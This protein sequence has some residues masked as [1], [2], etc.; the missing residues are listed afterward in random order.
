MQH[1]YFSDGH[2]IAHYLVAHNT[3]QKPSL[4]EFTAAFN[5]YCTSEIGITY[6]P[7]TTSELLI[8]SL[9]ILPCKIF[10]IAQML[11]ICCSLHGTLRAKAGNSLLGYL[12]YTGSIQQCNQH[13]HYIHDSSLRVRILI[14]FF[15]ELKLEEF[16]NSFRYVST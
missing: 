9:S 15:L 8:Q 7:S 13:Q 12:S 1:I 3:V 14:Y 11:L 5:I 16:K 4:R 10:K 6:F 2:S